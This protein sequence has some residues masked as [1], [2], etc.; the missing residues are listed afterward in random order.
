MAA[1]SLPCPFLSQKGGAGAGRDTSG[2]EGGRP[3]PCLSLL[4]QG[5]AACVCPAPPGM[6]PWAAAV[7]PARLREAAVPSAGSPGRGPASSRQTPVTPQAGDPCP[8][9]PGPGASLSPVKGPAANPAAAL[10]QGWDQDRCK[11]RRQTAPVRTRGTFPKAPAVTHPFKCLFYAWVRAQ[12]S[13]EA[14][15]PIRDGWLGETGPGPREP[16]VSLDK[17]HI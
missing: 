17:A 1:G 13:P 16:T 9:Q 14:A 3:P 12:G 4:P 7:S 10:R 2:W 8:C 5:Q 15:M 6:S 11:G